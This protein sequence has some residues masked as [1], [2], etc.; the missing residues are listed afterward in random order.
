MN[1]FPSGREA[2]DGKPA[3]NPLRPGLRMS[4]DRADRIHGN[5][6]SEAVRDL[7][8]NEAPTDALSLL[9]RM[10]STG[11]QLSI[12]FCTCSFCLQCIDCAMTLLFRHG[13]ALASANCNALIVRWHSCCSTSTHC[14]LLV[15]TCE[16]CEDILVTPCSS[17]GF[18]WFQRVIH[19]SRHHCCA[20]VHHLLHHS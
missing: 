17:V 14:D 5:R 3:H 10:R 4:G 13:H 12:L 18:N 16:S 7:L 8:G 15:S 2:D 19:E 1:P 6:E 9:I 11:A 20:F